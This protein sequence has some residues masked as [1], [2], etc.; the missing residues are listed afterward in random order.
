VGLA[1]GLI[2][3]FAGVSLAHYVGAAVFHDAIQVTPILPFLIVFAAMVI[4]LAGA[5]Q[6]LYRTLRM[7]PAGILREGV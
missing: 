4:A 3:A 7:E 2:G 1:G 5:A 6:P